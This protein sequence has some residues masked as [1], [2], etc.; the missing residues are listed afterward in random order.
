MSASMGPRPSG[1]GDSVWTRGRL[2][3]IEP[4][5]N[6]AAAIRPRRRDPADRP[7]GRGRCFNGAA[8]IRPRRPPEDHGGSA[9][10][11][12]GSFNG[13]A[14]IRPRRPTATPGEPEAVDMASMGPRPS[15]RGDHPTGAASRVAG[16]AA[17][18]GPRP[19][20][21]GDG[22]HQG[23]PR[24]GRRVLQWGRDH[25]AAETSPGLLTSLH[26]P[27]FNGAATIRPRRRLSRRPHLSPWGSASMGPRPS[28]RGDNPTDGSLVAYMCLLQWGRDHQAAE[29]PR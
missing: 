10:H 28:G 25:Q 24:G 12:Q 9:R 20:G 11:C 22:E 19:S 14:T 7:W 23:A 16:L 5:F 3:W 27:R 8:T 21:R 13:A 1:R 18:M 15:G 17:S 26:H 4:C 29:T 2:A 6:G